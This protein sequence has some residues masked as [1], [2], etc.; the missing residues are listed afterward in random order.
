M[1]TNFVDKSLGNSIYYWNNYG[2]AQEVIAFSFG[3]SE[4]IFL[5]IAE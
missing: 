3:H 1:F 2:I 4:H 5:W